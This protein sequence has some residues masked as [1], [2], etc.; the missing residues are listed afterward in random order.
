MSFQEDIA[1]RKAD[2]RK[3]IQDVEYDY[4]YPLDNNLHPKSDMHKYI[5]ENLL[6]F[7][8][9]SASVGSP[10][11][12]EWRHMDWQMQAYMPTK[13][14]DYAT[15][16]KDSRKPV[17]IVLPITMASKETF[18]TYMSSAF[19]VDPVFRY[20]GIGGPQNKVSAAV[21][22]KL[23]AAQSMFWRHALALQTMWSDAF[24][25]GIGMVA[26]EWSKHRV[27]HIV[28]EQVTEL[29][30]T[31]TRQVGL[32]IDEGDLVS[33]AEETVEAEGNRLR[34][35]DPYQ[36]FLDP[37]ATPNEIYD[38]EY[39]GWVQRTNS[40][41]LLRREDD[42]EERMFNAKYVRMFAEQ[43]VATST[44][45]ECAEHGRDARGETN[46]L[47]E[48]DLSSA[49][50]VLHFYVDLVPYEWGLSDTK[51]PEKWLFAVA[52]DEI[53]I[54]A[55]PLDLYHGMFPI[56]MCAPTSDGHSVLPVSKAM[57]TY[58]MQKA[59]DWMM[60]TYID[61]MRKSINGTVAYDSGAIRT[62]DVMNPGPGKVIRS[63]NPGFGEFDIRKHI[64][65]LTDNAVTQQNIPSMMLLMDMHKQASGML[66]IVQGDLSKMPERP[67]AQGIQAAQTGALSRLQWMAQVIETQAMRPLGYQLAY[68]TMQFME[69]E[70][71]VEIAGR[72]E[73][74][75]RREYGL[76]TNEDSL[77][78]SYQMLRPGF[79][80]E[81]RNGV[82]PHRENG[83]AWTD[84]LMTILQQEGAVPEL[85]Q[86]VGGIMPIFMHWARI[87]GA[88][89]LRE[90]VREGGQMPQMNTQVVP[91]EQVAAGVDS[92][93]LQPMGEMAV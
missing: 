57:Q 13:E 82:L 33:I 27:R 52:G 35:L 42:P 16:Q 5:V 20:K 81:P 60:K 75:L 54:R 77:S 89:D 45:Y 23:I 39:F 31:I 44:L 58:P 76:P 73:E 46:V 12:E 15:L 11:K 17:T 24:T 51:V 55:Q 34:P 85:T 22:E 87:N 48:S 2:L 21:M 8:R 25:Y 47:G 93:Q 65:S 70:T 92:G 41:D 28:D 78:V 64:V 71:A 67:T 68:N 3:Q 14:A 40:M 10:V 32:D 80:L 19:L 69:M 1:N 30:A 61:D 84:V 18:L 43:K 91:D 29:M 37:K 53:L 90:F 66:D 50:D 6:D 36:V 38:S 79:T 86:S 59:V 49:V 62:D 4:E 7:A 63:K 83:Q 72:H 88:E 9:Q 56:A 26:P 74:L